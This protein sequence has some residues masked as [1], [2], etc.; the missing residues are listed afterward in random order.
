MNHT[1]SCI[2]AL[3]G[4]AWR[5]PMLMLLVLASLSM[6]TA[7]AAQVADGHYDNSL[8]L[9]PPMGWSSWT[10]L[11]KNISED[12]I[13]AQAQGLSDTLKSHGYVYV[14]IDDGW[15][16]DPRNGCDDF[17]RFAV[18][19]A[20]F[21]HG[22]Q[23]MGDFVHGLGLKF[24]IYMTA[25]VPAAAYNANS[26]IEGTSLHVRDIVQLPLINAYPD[27]IAPNYQY[28]IDFNKPGAGA[29]MDSWAKMFASW[30]V[31]YVKL[32]FINVGFP[33]TADHGT[34]DHAQDMSRALL[35]CGRPIFFQISNNLQL[36]PP[37]GEIWKGISNAWRANPDIERDNVSPTL[38]FP[39]T[40]WGHM[41]NSQRGALMR[42]YNNPEDV[43]NLAGPGGWNDLD[44]LI[45][46]YGDA[47][48]T[49]LTDGEKQFHLAYYAMMSSS[50]LLG[51]DMTNMDPGDLAMLQNDEIIA[52]DQT[53]VPATWRNVNSTWLLWYKPMADG[54][55][56]VLMASTGA[57]S[58]VKSIGASWGGSSGANFDIPLP[59]SGSQNVRDVFA[60]ADLGRFDNGISF[61]LANHTCRLLKVGG[62]NAPPA[63]AIQTASLANGTVGVAYS[64]TFGASGGT[65]GYTWSVT[66]G[67]PPSGLSLSSGI[68][69]GTPTA[70]GTFAFTIAVTDSAA[71]TTSRNF[72][73][74]IAPATAPLLITT[75]SPL[76]GGSV[77]SA[78]SRTFSSSGGVPGYTWS[79]TGG[80]LPGGLSLS[81]GV[82]AGTPTA[83]GTFTFNV[84]VTD[85][86][87]AT[88]SKAF[89]LVIA[90]AAVPLAITTTS[91]L[92]GGTVGV[93]YA[94]TFGAT[95]GSP[96]YTWSLTGGALPIGLAL[97]D[98]SLAGTP[99]AAGTF[100]FTLTVTDGAGA[101]ASS[102]YSL[103]IA[104]AAVALAITTSSPLVDGA[105]GAAYAQAFDA[106]GGRPGYTWSLTGGTLPDGLSLDAGMLSGTPTAAGTFA[107]TLTVADTAGA[108]AS[109]AYSLAI[110]PDAAALR[111]TTPSPLTD[112]TVGVAF[113]QAF[114]ASGGTPGYTWAVTGGT[115][116]DGLSLNAGALVGTPTSAG[117]ST[118]TMT[119]TDGAGA[120]AT[121]EYALPV[122]ALAPVITSVATVSGT[123]GVPLSYAIVASHAP[124][125]FGATGLPTG[126]TLNAAT[127]LIS[128]TPQA[129][130]TST[131]TITAS[132][133][134]GSASAPL[135]LTVA[136]AAS[137]GS[138]GGGSSNHSC[139]GGSGLSVLALA[140][141]FV[142]L[143]LRR[144]RRGAG[145]ARE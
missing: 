60:R 49:G 80:A 9:T 43:H 144:P 92:T 62:T 59:L 129:A 75:S 24:G 7:L 10:F 30:G 120:T 125:S 141:L 52:I 76:P 26:S 1:M 121:R 93:A 58:E 133:A 14:N 20:K 115:L 83:A 140:M 116:P 118:F 38:Q 51:S 136:A 70:A 124:T 8:G 61:A 131:V 56:A 6:P 37:Y 4:K 105:V 87:A 128:G 25:G 100:T 44:S 66:G 50:L 145:Q 32:D 68:L 63:L 5:A 16:V 142:A 104:P 102:A 126:L 123:V 112:A 40:D 11:R 71:A 35:H 22:M 134:A 46:G 74:S 41:W 96:G 19:T 48:R 36:N 55:Y 27:I 21:P 69:A 42:T 97:N 110:A 13:K 47:S 143:P 95:G 77:G 78:Y 109:K 23:A 103:V 15:Q 88:A 117:T 89:S 94:K 67:T 119:V 12:I 79:L 111:I 82:L 64:Q 2:T 18:D 31:D 139:G 138:S 113:S 65:P 122:V 73:V 135:I 3:L 85:G 101:T 108:T 81:E 90:P 91:P 72:S 130:G 54:G 53:P 45:I 34:I 84:T 29:Y 114:A 57:S 33:G 39:V 107:F 127:G 86:A 137:G 99:S 17:G 106:S 98:G 132:N 28:R